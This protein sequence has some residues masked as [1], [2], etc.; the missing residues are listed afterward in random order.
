MPREDLL[1]RISSAP[2]L[3]VALDIVDLDLAVKISREASKIGFDIVEVGTPLLKL[4]G[5]TAISRIKAHAENSIVMVDTKTADAGG[6]EAEIVARAGGDAM[7]V[8]A[9][10]SDEV[11]QETI[12]R[13]RDLGVSTWV[14]LIHVQEP[15]RRAEE[16]RK[17]EPDIVIMHIGVDVQRRRG[18]S[19]DALERDIKEAVERGFKIAVAGG[20]KGE[21]IK[22]MARIGA[23]I[24]IIGGWITRHH[25]PVERM[26]ESIKI[27]RG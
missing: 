23:S 2:L 12:S 6:M 4:Y 8:L 10:S 11:I 19:V 17:F 26:K 13:G 9:L 5:S 20:I 14:D 15:L 22:K 27:L 24:I 3:Q 21:T 7:S 1:R 18:I 16:L 25:D